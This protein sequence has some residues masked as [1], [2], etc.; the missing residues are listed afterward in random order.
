MIDYDEQLENAHVLTD[1]HA[2]AVVGV[3]EDILSLLSETLGTAA[4]QIS[5][6]IHSIA[7]SGDLSL[8]PHISSVGQLTE[9]IVTDLDR[10]TD[11]Y[12]HEI[13]DAGINVP[14]HPGILRD[15]LDVT[16]QEWLPAVFPPVAAMMGVPSSNG[17]G[18]ANGS[19]VKIT[20]ITLPPPD[21]MCVDPSQAYDPA[22]GQCGPPT[23]PPTPTPPGPPCV[24]QCHVDVNGRE[25]C[26]PEETAP[27]DYYTA[28]L[29]GYDRY[30]YFDQSDQCWYT[31]DIKNHA[32]ICRNWCAPGSPNTDPTCPCVDPPLCERYPSLPECQTPPPPPECPAGT[33]L[34]PI[35]GQCV[36][37]VPVPPPPVPCPDGSDPPCD[38]P[39]PIPPPPPP[40][41][42]CPAPCPPP[43]IVVQVQPATCPTPPAIPPGPPTTPPPPG[44]PPPRQSTVAPVAAAPMLD[45][46]SPDVCKN[47]SGAISEYLNPGANEQP[48]PPKGD[49]DLP[50]WMT[51]LRRQGRSI[52][53]LLPWIDSTEFDA[54]QNVK[55]AVAEQAVTFTSGSTLI[56][57]V[58]DVIGIRGINNPYLTATMG[59]TLGMASYG[60]K[61]TGFPIQYLTQNINYAYQYLNPQL[62]PGQDGVNRLWVT[63]RITNE[64]WDCLTR[65]NGNLT[66]WQSSLASTQ[67]GRANIA[68]L[69]Q[70]FMRGYLNQKELDERA[71]DI[72]WRE[73]KYVQEVKQLAL[74]LPTQDSQIRYAVRDVW[75]A[76]VVSQYGYDEGW[77]E[78]FENNPDA[79]RLAQATGVDPFYLRKD[80]HAHWQIPSNTQLYD[81][82]H[83]FHPLRPERVKWESV[84]P[85]GV[86]PDGTPESDWSYYHRGPLVV[87]AEMVADAVRTNDM[88]PGWVR[89]MVELSYRPITNTDAARAYI[90][91]SFDES[92]LY[93]SFI[94]N[95]YNEVNAKLL[96]DFYKLL[97]VKRL[98]NETGV[99]TVRKISQHYKAGDI[100]RQVAAN[101]MTEQLGD[102]AKVTKLLDRTDLEL[103]AETRAIKIKGIRKQFLTAGIEAADARVY[104]DLAG[105][106]PSQSEILIA[107]WTWEREHSAR[108]ATAA[109]LCKWHSRGLIDAEE[110]YRRLRILGFSV[111]DSARISKVCAIEAAEKLAAKEERERRQRLKDT[112][113]ACK[114][115]IGL[116]P[117]LKDTLGPLCGVGGSKPQGEGGK[118]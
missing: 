7:G 118:P 94:A 12:L 30:G 116:F 39:T 14:T 25:S 69:I 72:G 78:K 16:P 13:R 32:V 92:Q 106:M 84:N 26:I 70:L 91:G 20:P 68:E 48:L 23:G 71:M 115:L 111:N 85:R 21:P 58:F 88:A 59:S 50:G 9:R 109:M 54:P 66:E 38:E 28:Q 97:S 103:E 74:Q 75:D 102:F 79:L 86:N 107:R 105:V 108:N 98:S 110:Y 34:D 73:P 49:G 40:P 56:D 77:K 114:Y 17:E 33:R 8:D 51:W 27:V 57:K 10:K 47:V 5:A 29:L 18:I 4:G 42:Q 89:A 101:L 64:T 61:I 41:G 62:L 87:T 15:M 104:L 45:W 76:K 117:Q 37:A 112:Q 60:E 67:V 100:S 99:W 31:L 46:G 24:P 36:P 65:A 93:W 90:V 6:L 11:R 83:R 53:A 82:L 52:S 96:V 80:W 1:E 22:T 95:G 44:P 3:V 2:S 55:D 35:T 63:G 19:D 113:T 43:P 81:G